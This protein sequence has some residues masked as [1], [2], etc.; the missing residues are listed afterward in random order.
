MELYDKVDIDTLPVQPGDQGVQDAI[1]S[2]ALNFTKQQNNKKM[3]KWMWET[4][5]GGEEKGR[6]EGRKRGNNMNFIFIFSKA[7]PLRKTCNQPMPII[8]QKKEHQKV[9]R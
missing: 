9:E 5:K 3:N 6:E 2:T 7:R 1:F 4:K 8:F